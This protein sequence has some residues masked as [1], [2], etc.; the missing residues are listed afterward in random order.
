MKTCTRC[1]FPKPIEEFVKST[2]TKSGRGAHCLVCDRDRVADRR[3]DPS[4]RIQR[5][6]YSAEY[7]TNNLEVLRSHDRQAK[8]D[9]QMWLNN[10]KEKPCVD[11][12]SVFPPCCMD[13]DHVAGTKVK[14]IGQLLSCSKEIVLSEIAKCEL[15]CACCHRVRTRIQIP[16]SEDPRRKEF[17]RKI[18]LLKQDSCMD[19]GFKFQPVSMDFD[20]VRGT[21][22]ATV[23]QMRTFS[24]GRVTL[25]LAKCDLV[26]A[27]CHRIRTNNRVVMVAA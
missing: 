12:R 25:E 19:C 9:Q 27:N 24:W 22:V 16:E 17:Y 4:V 5:I 7:R 23:S 1:G 10:L 6:T 15:V 8:R 2:Q 26:C 3:Q 11:C 21:K 18:A 14:G 13:F 20:H